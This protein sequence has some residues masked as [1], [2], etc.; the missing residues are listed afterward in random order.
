MKFKSLIF[1]VVV[2]AIVLT[3]SG[4][5]AVQTMVEH[6][7]LDVQ[8]KMS[9]PIFLPPPISLEDKIVWVDIRNTSDKDINLEGILSILR[10]K[11]Y[12]VTFN[13]AENH[14]YRLQVQ[15]LQVEKTSLSA[16]QQALASGYGG[17][18]L[19]G[20]A[21]AAIGS[22]GGYGTAIG[23]GLGGALLGGLVETIIN[24]SVKDI[25]YM[26]ITDVQISVFSNKKIAQKTTADMKQGTSTNITQD[27]G[28]ESDWMLYRTRIVST[29]NKVNLKFDEALPLLQSGISRVVAGI[30]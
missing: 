23:A 10:Q 12:V 18:L 22:R 7:N 30:F 6:K 26:A 24:S 28:E 1:T 25:T 16:A 3:M 8:T 5:A 20:A 21:G 27:V 15:L 13:P 11:G 4:C 2:S 14:R 29:A 17:A 9:D 19:G